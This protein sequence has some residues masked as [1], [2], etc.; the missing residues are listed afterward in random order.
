[1]RHLGNLQNTV[2]LS[3]QSHKICLF[4][5]NICVPELGFANSFDW[6]HDVWQT[7][8]TFLALHNITWKIPSKSGK[9]KT[10]WQRR[11]F[12]K[13]SGIRGILCYYCRSYCDRAWTVTEIYVKAIVSVMTDVASHYFRDVYFQC[14]RSTG[15]CHDLCQRNQL[16]LLKQQLKEAL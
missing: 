11:N 16:Y 2:E 8:R 10:L 3:Y 13:V 7:E 6:K 15:R 9:S 14:F 1:M 5:A 12:K 4:Q